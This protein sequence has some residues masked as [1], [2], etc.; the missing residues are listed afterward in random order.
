MKLFVGIGEGMKAKLILLTTLLFL[1]GCFLIWSPIATVKKF[2]AAAQKGD[3][4]TMTKLFSNK[5]IQ[6][7]GLDKIRSNNQS[8]A[9]TAQ[10][11]AASGGSYRMQNVQETSRVNGVITYNFVAE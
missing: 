11:A 2:M 6:K 5:A 3:L 1:T 8:F 9:E 7:I 4:E 10:P